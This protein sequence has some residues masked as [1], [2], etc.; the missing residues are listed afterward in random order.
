ME[1]G[2][3]IYIK[4]DGFSTDSATSNVVTVGGVDCPIISKNYF[5]VKNYNFNQVF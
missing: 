5:H 2:A 4:G 3:Y 1:G